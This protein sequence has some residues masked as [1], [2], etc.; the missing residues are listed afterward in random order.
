MPAPSTLSVR[1]PG[2]PVD[3]EQA[4]APPDITGGQADTLVTVSQAQLQ[5]MVN[6]AVSKARAQPDRPKEAD[7]PESSTVDP[8]K[9]KEM[10]LTKQGWVVP[11]RFGEPAAAQR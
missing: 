5:A 8:A 2:A 6:A 10:T 7:L 11:H 9:I 1:T 4:E 3:P